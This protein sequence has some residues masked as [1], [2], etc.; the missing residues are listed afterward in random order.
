MVDLSTH[1]LGLKLPTPIIV[2]S[3]PY[4]SDVE[5]MKEMEAAGAGA[6]VLPSLFEEQ[7]EIEDLRLQHSR[8]LEKKSWPDALSHIPDMEGYNHGVGGYLAHIYATKR[9]LTIPVI[10]SLSG[11]SIAGWERYARLLQAAGADAIELNIYHLPTN[12]HTTSETVERQYINLVRSVKSVVDIPVSVKLNPYIS[13]LPHFCHE[14]QLAGASGLVMFNRFYQPDFDI[15]NQTVIPELH[16]SSSDQLLLRLRWVALLY[17]RLSTEFAVTGGVHTGDDALKAFLAGAKV[18][19]MT[20]AILMNGIEHI[21]TVLERVREWMGEHGY[22]TIDSFRGKLSP[23]SGQ[24][25]D[26]F[27]RAN[28]IQTLTSYSKT[29]EEGKQ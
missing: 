2:S 8:V 5:K 12:L 18:V 21:G 19:M 16:L 10:A 20:S 6:V 9:A 7:V 26:A 3:N 29:I 25:T 4:N 13:A 14:L 28:Y 23:V 24:K 1:Y 22:E 27:E 11:T 17:G 15:E